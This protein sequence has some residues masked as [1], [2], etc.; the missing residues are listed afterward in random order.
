MQIPVLVER[1]DSNGYRAR[2]PEPFGLTA[3]GSTEEEALQKLRELVQ[4]RLAAG[5]RLVQLDV[6]EEHP[7]ARFVGRWK[8]GDPVIEEWKKAVEE[9]RRQID[10]DPDAL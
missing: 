4:S 10:E 5:A 1:V 7:W 6:P 3:E 9:Y 2:G 8:E